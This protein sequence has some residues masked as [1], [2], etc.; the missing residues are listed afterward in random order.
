MSKGN[1]LVEKAMKKLESEGNV[2][3][4]GMKQIAAA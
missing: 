4:E 2:A 1:A 3:E